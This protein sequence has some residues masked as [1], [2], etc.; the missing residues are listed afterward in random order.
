MFTNTKLVAQWE[1][2]SKGPL[3]TDVSLVMLFCAAKSTAVLGVLDGGRAALRPDPSLIYSIGIFPLISRPSLYVKNILCIAV[4]F[5]GA[6]VKV[7]LLP[8]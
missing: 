4:I 7:L 5:H 8:K 6:M 2:F 1:R 3:Y